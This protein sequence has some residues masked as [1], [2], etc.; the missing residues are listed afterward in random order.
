[1]QKTNTKASMA[2]LARIERS[3]SFTIGMSLQYYKEIHKHILLDKR[4]RNFQRVKLCFSGLPK[5]EPIGTCP[6]KDRGTAHGF[7]LCQQD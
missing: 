6:L 4:P 5:F 3:F 1:M 2:F 7:G